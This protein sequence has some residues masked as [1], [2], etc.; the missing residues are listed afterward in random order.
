MEELRQSFYGALRKLLGIP[1]R[2]RGVQN[3]ENESN[4]FASIVSS[5]SRRFHSLYERSEQIFSR[6][7]QIDREFDEWT[8][9]AQVLRNKIFL[10]DYF[11]EFKSVNDIERRAVFFWIL[12]SLN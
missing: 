8:A 1:L 4:L 11:L 5:E 12:F 2:M 9:L 3:T 7:K 6:L 10:D